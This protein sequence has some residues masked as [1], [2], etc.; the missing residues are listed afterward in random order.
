[1]TAALLLA[2]LAVPLVLAAALTV[3]RLRSGA[4]AVAPWASAPALAAAF[5]ARGAELDLPWLLFGARLG[6][7]RTG[8]LF[9]G[10]AAALWLAAGVY[11]RGYLSEDPARRRFFLF[12]LLTMAGNLGVAVA[13][14]MASFAL[15][16]ALMGLSGFGLV[17]HAGTPTARQAARVYVA[18]V[19]AGEMLIFAAMILGV[20]AAGGSVLFADVRAATAQAS[21]AS[22]EVFVLLALAG[23]GVKAGALPLHVWLPLAHPAAPTPASAV[24]SGAMIKAGLL[25]WMRIL[26][27]GEASLPGPAAL[28]V[29]AGLAAAFLG[30]L[31]GVTQRDP[32]TTLAYSSISQMGLVT[33]AIGIGL[34][35]PVEWTFVEEAILLFALHHGVSKAALFLGVGVAPGLPPVGGGAAAGVRWRGRLRALA[36]LLPAAALAGAPFTTGAIAKAG[37]EDLAP[38]APG[39]WPRL[40]PPLL[41]LSAFGTSLLMARFLW[42]VWPRESPRAGPRRGLDLP[43]AALALGTLAVPIVWAGPGLPGVVKLV[44]GVAPIAAAAAIAAGIA[45]SVRSGASV[46]WQIPAGD[47]LWP[48]LAAV[49]PL[50]AFETRIEEVAAR[51][52]AGVHDAGAWLLTRT[53]R[54]EIRSGLEPRLARGTASGLLFLVLAAL[55][56]V[57][58]ALG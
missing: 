37:I 36:L 40:L 18:L 3:P 6:L 42:L 45:G 7:D 39:A 53:Q 56:G 29:A 8:A 55:I 30:V 43:F 20:R 5:A 23:F 52:W 31:A 38:L 57:A 50:L 58:V 54:L 33:V 24:L 46:R 41:T 25:G 14:D 26:P 17:G 51:T 34:A 16:F 15:A 19:V 21:G 28:A 11:A 44:S 1:V 4:L 10:L 2:A 32:K 48:F 35:A 47:L 22:G 12:H 49:R 9:L 27:L 13:Q